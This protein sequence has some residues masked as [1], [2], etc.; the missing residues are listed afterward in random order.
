[1]AKIASVPP[2]N[3][4]DD[5]LLKNALEGGASLEALAKGAVRFSR[6]FTLGELR[7]RWRSLLYDD[8]VAAEAS[9]R[10][11]EFELS[12]PN[13]LSKFNRF[14]ISRATVGVIP[15]KRKG[16][17][18][19]RQYYERR[20]K[21][22]TFN[23]FDSSL[24][25]DPNVKYVRDEADCRGNLTVRNEPL[26]GNYMVD[27]HVQNYYEFPE[28]GPSGLDHVSSSMRNNVL[29]NECPLVDNLQEGH[30][31]LAEG[32]LEDSYE[33][34]TKHDNADEQVHASRDT[35]VDFRNCQVVGEV[36]TSNSQQDLPLWKSIEDVLAPE[37]LL[38]IGLEVKHND[39]VET[40]LNLDD[41]DDKNINSLGD[42]N[43]QIMLEVRVLDNE[44]N[45]ST[46]ISGG[47]FVDISDCLLNLT[48]ENEPLVM[49]VDGEDM[50]ND[51]GN[52]PS[53]SPKVVHNDDVPK[54]CQPQTLESRTCHAVSEDVVNAEKEASALFPSAGVDQ[55]IICSELNISSTKSLQTP[56]SSEFRYEMMECTLNTEDPE[57]P[58]NDDLVQPG[59]KEA[60]DP[61][62]SSTN[63]RSSTLES[64]SLTREENP[65]GPFMASQTV[66]YIPKTNPKPEP[67]NCNRL[68]SISKQADNVLAGSS[69]C[70]SAHPSPKFA[71]H[72]VLNEEGKAVP[73]T[74]RELA[75][76]STE[77]GATDLA[78]MEPETDPTPLD[79][80]KSE[81]ELD[82]EDDDVPYFSDIENMILEM[83]L[84][85]DFQ[86]SYLS[87][88]VSRYQ[89]ED[90][91]MKIVRLEQCA[92]SSMNRNI[93][94]RG[95]FAVFYGRHLK[96]YIKK[97]EVILGRTTE[98]Y[99]VDIDLGKER[100]TNSISRR[101]A[102]L[103][104]E[105]D[106]SFSLMNLGKNP[107]FVNG[108]EV[109]Y[110]ELSGLSPSSLIEI[111]GL[112]FVF[113]INH[114]YV[115]RYLDKNGRNSIER[116]SKFEWSAEVNP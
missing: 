30:C 46:G 114:K 60:S 37:M 86:D 113:E 109:G 1:M 34:N 92:K 83:D 110:R 107:I 82:G 47:G 54:V 64:I 115:R 17:S 66:G 16:E 33:L 11:V 13:L 23:T 8:G 39:A 28:R 52:M 96:Q 111:R 80:D 18:I 90:M 42:D 2:W 7:E 99:E 79:N 61:A 32:F 73:V 19:R 24:I 70:R 116:H 43:S 21:L 81:E 56:C 14:S 5:L 67:S 104:M 59:F 38:D 105:G 48:T 89:H 6:K 106:G 44:I 84:S 4:E 112:S 102:L 40:L 87:K 25:D 57:I 36:G 95:A 50:M 35:L 27:D 53:N 22:C 41:V 29:A 94:S 49:G 31:S 10:M 85:P 68:A 100:N 88:E 97:T 98:N 20:K 76:L 26:D 93:A 101:Q 72:Q 78:F 71:A 55:D 108:K 63:P 75:L 58:C 69:Q 65:A 91:K 103:K 15:P 45:R 51:S 9:A 3:P 77:A 12:N 74:T 62:T